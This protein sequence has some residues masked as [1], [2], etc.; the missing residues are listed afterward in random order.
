MDALHGKSRADVV[1]NLLAEV[2]DVALGGVGLAEINLDR[3]LERLETTVAR[4]CHRAAYGTLHIDRDAVA[5][6]VCGNAE[7]GIQN[8]RSAEAIKELPADGAVVFRYGSAQGVQF[9]YKGLQR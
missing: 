9:D 1:V 4:N 5:H 6:Y 2:E 7:G 8:V 3:K